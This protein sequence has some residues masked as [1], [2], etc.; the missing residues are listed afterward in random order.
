MDNLHEEN[1]KSFIDI[2]DLNTG[3]FYC[4]PGKGGTQCLNSDGSAQLIY[5]RMQFH[6]KNKNPNKIT[7]GTRQPTS[8]L[9]WE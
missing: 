6:L 5:K 7:L 2:K 4:V 9:Y 8:N 3:A 1:L